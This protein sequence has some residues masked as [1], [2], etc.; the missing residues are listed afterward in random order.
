MRV[1][2]DFQSLRVES[3]R[4][5]GNFVNVMFCLTLGEKNRILFLTFAR[6]IS[7]TG[8]LEEL[9]V[10]SCRP[11]LEKPSAYRRNMRCETGRSVRERQRTSRDKFAQMSTGVL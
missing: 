8:V 5:L 4:D 11:T 7:S 6:I 1:I 3:S 2:V 9:M 10:E